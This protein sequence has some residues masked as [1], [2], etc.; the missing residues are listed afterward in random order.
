M[1][2]IIQ[3]DGTELGIVDEV[4]YIKISP[5][6]CFIPTDAKNAIGVAFESKPSN[7]IGHDEIENA[8]TVVVSQIDGGKIIKE[9]VSYSEL[10]AAIREGVNAVD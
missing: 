2:R 5:T 8:E 6:G 10:A 3:L 7:L 4:R 9:M 1:Y